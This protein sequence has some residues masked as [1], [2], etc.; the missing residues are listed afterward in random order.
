M[1]DFDSSRRFHA[2]NCGVSLC[3]LVAMGFAS[4]AQ[5]QAQA[6]DASVQTQQASSANAQAGEDATEDGQAIVVV[7]VRAAL[8]TSQNIKKN[9]DTFVDSI[10]ATDI[11]AFP[12]KSA[13]EALARVPGITVNRL[14]SADD[15]THPSGEPTG[16]L[17][18][19]LPQVRTE[20][21]GRDSFSADS[22][23]GLQFNDVSPELLA[24]VDA[25]KNQTAEM[26]EGGIAGTVNLRTRLPFDQ[27]GLLVTGNFKYN[28][29]D[30][31]D[32]WT[33]EFS[34][35][36]SN[37]W[38]TP[39]GRFGLLA[40]YAQSH[41]VTRTESVIMD[42]IDTYCTAGFGTPAAGN[43]T[44]GGAIGCTANPFGGNGFALVPDGIR[45]SEVDYDRKRRG[46]AAAA[47]YEN[48]SGTLRATV[49]YVD[50]HYRN[51]WFERA[52]H[53]ILEGTYFNTPAFNPR[54]SS[55]LGP[56][57][58][59]GAFV[60]GSNGMLQSGTITQ[61]HGSFSGTYDSLQ[62]AINAGSAVAGMP[63]VN[64]C[65]AGANCTTLRDGMYLQNEARNF[66]HREGTRDFSGNIKWDVSDRLHLN[67]DGQYIEASTYNNDILVATGS[68]A[69]YQYSVNGDGTPQIK[70]LPGSNVNY[71]TGGLANPHNYWL[72]FI[73]GHVED[74]NADEIALR[75]DLE[76][77]FSEGG[78]LDSLKVGVRYADRHQKVRY[79]TFNWTPIAA[80]WNCNGPGFNIDNTTGGA[81]PTNTGNCGGNAGHAPFSGYGAGI[82]ESYDMSG[83][84]D[85][86]VYANGPLVFLNRDTLKDFGKLLNSLGG[87]KTNSPL[88]TGYTA[89]CDRPEATVDNCFTPGEVMEVREKTEAAYA[90]LRFGGDDKTIFGG[91]S[92]VGNVGVRVVQTRERSDGGIAFPATN[93]F[94]NLPACGTPLSGNDIVNPSCYLTPAIRAFANGGSIPNT[95]KSSTTDW[96][97]SF[98]V[99]FGLDTKSFIRF[100]YSRA[101]SRPDFGYLRN[102]VAI[103]API[104]NATPDSPYIVYNS[105]NAAH[106]AANVTGYNF[107]F[108]ANSGN[109]G[110][111][112]VIAD[113]FDLSFEHYMGRS[114]SFTLSGFYKQLNNSISYG[115]FSRTFANGGSTQTVRLLG[116]HNADDGGKLMGFEAAYQSFFD[117]LPGLLSGLGAQLNYTYVHQSGINNSN[118][119]TASSSGD[120]GA[121]GIGQPA[122]G[123]AGNVIDSHRLAGISDHTFN[124]V[125]LYEKGP[126]GFRLAYN[127]RSRYLTQNLD[128]CIGLPVFQKAAGYL[129]GSIRFSVNRFLEL[130]VDA[131]NLLNTRSVYQQQIFGDSPATPD[132][133]PVFQDSAWSRVDRRFQFGVRAK[134]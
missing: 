53:T 73:Q 108:Q 60:F 62:S 52:S 61:P 57:D 21:N 117:F 76:Y 33:P 88:G 10:T 17:I 8:D 29:G 78:W 31:S 51:G 1:R 99:R 39:I 30:R 12:D 132:A 55:I 66:A 134:F 89:I 6:A 109:A 18:R 120:V 90:M 92:V 111:K 130:S 27:K 22:A 71:A 87:A 36:I 37:T 97:P 126:V 75:G 115:E 56:A 121:V 112:P 2:L 96:L 103:N 124:A 68:M 102:T 101:L 95:Y 35:L 133:K 81:Y 85:G 41:V 107:V 15:S 72:P 127:W 104:L 70:L 50:S 105:P 46:I 59:T 23:R 42:K 79:S 125:A 82:W 13:A 5:A 86:N 20:F 9:A 100:A 44:A 4:A 28:Y 43:V 19:G 110:L 131:S 49:Q 118:L 58:G 45:Y 64:F 123:G 106:T 129:D 113:Q 114:S 48:N 40:D 24:G 80:N 128:C 116:P 11:G 26:I 84:Y 25:Y 32:R 119:I 83:L 14:Q 69:N 34:A 94:D 38:E 98:N 67:L 16:V 74:N 122:L 7:G 91:V 3:A 47:Q 77:E 93:I 63:F 54:T 65:G